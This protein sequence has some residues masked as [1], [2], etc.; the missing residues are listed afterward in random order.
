M[1]QPYD[2]LFQNIYL[3]IKWGVGRSYSP[4]FCHHNIFN[5][6][7]LN[8]HFILGN[9]SKLMNDVPYCTYMN[10]R[11]RYFCNTISTWNPLHTCIIVSKSIIIHE[12]IIDSISCVTS[13]IETQSSIIGIAYGGEW[14]LFI[15]I[16]L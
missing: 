11:F 9:F 14:A 4:L 12:L 6:F 7:F 10:D 5:Q 15:C 3:F 13:F 8:D 2:S 16:H 1:R